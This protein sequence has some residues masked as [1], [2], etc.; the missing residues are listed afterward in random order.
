MPRLMQ[1]HTTSRPRRGFT[2]AEMLVSIT[3]LAIVGGAVFR[4]IVKQQQSYKDSTRTAAMQRELRLTGSFLP[5]EMRSASSAGLDVKSMQED[6]VV[7][8]ANIGSGIVCDRSGVAQIILPPLN[9]AHVTTTNW[10]TQPVAGDSLFIYDEGML[11]GSEDDAWVRR[12]IVSIGNSNACPGAPSTDA[13]LDAGKPRWH[14][15]VSGGALPDSVKTGA[16]VRFARPVRYQLYQSPSV[17]RDWYVGFQEY[18]NGSWSAIDAVGGPFRPFQSGD[19]NPSG[20]QFRYYDSLGVR[21][22]PAD[23][24][25]RL[26]RIDVFLRTN[27]GLAA[28]TERRPNDLRDSVLMRV[29]L[30]NFK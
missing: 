10:Y 28:V 8:L 26:S 22:Y 13:A 24:P 30:R 1:T 3:I 2:L 14:V 27:A 29:G 7:F 18:V 16:V 23:N 4:V 25:S 17:T 6:A 5:A 19:A 12:S 15:N 11:K 9:T 21:L 20:L